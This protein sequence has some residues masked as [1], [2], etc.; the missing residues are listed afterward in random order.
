[1]RRI[2]LTVIF[3]V[4]AS[5]GAATAAL[6]QSGDVPPLKRKRL[7]TWLREGTYR[8][9]YTAEPEVHPSGGP[10]GGNVRTYYNS[11]LVGDLRAARP[12]FRK[13]ATM[14]KEL[15]FSGTDVVVG[16]AVL[17]KVRRNRGAGGEGWLWL[18][19]FDGTNADFF[20]RGVR[21]CANCH[22]GGQD[23]LLSP[24]RP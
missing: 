10:H 3:V 8:A 17:S 23:F 2:R 13:G 24:F 16:F 21:L 7:L 20:G 11:I 12:T 22:S 6:G 9:T 18:E 14:V 4:L 1:M 19:S 5:L 15:Y